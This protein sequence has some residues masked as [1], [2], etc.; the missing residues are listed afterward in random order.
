MKNVL[1]IFIAMILFSSCKKEEEG[2]YD[3]F[4][5]IVGNVSADING[6]PWK[7]DR[8]TM[9]AMQLNASKRKYA[10]LSFLGLDRN[11]AIS[12]NHLTLSFSLDGADSL[13]RPFTISRRVREIIGMPTV[14]EPTAFVVHEKELYQAFVE[15]T[16]TERITVV[17]KNDTFTGTFAFKAYTRDKFLEVTNGKFYFELK[18]KK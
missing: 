12:S 18:E 9:P 7:S 4:V 17:K 5:E 2:N 11:D 6:K 14:Y 16:L 15:D 10:T 8:L 1:L 3:T 13:S